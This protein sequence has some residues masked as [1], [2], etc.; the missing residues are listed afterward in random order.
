MNL[1]DALGRMFLD[2]LNGRRVSSLLGADAVEVNI[3]NP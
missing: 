2:P 3:N 1:T